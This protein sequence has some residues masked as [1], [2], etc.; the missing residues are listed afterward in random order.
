MNMFFFTHLSALI[1]TLLKKKNSRNRSHE[2]QIRA[3]DEEIEHF[4]TVKIH[5]I[6][7]YTAIVTEK[8]RENWQI[9]RE[10]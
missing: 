9:P 6:A 1:E 2:C 5:M 3:Y 8:K 7:I 10:L 4:A